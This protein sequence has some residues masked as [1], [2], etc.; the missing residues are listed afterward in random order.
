M[1]WLLKRL[2]DYLQ[3]AGRALVFMFE[4]LVPAERQQLDKVGGDKKRYDLEL[5]PHPMVRAI[6]ELQ[7]RLASE[8]DVWKIE[9]FDSVED[10]KT[11]VKT[12]APGWA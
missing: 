5:R 4:L 10:C 12:R 7:G 6:E 9:G 11:I 8:P 2:S 3:K 1:L